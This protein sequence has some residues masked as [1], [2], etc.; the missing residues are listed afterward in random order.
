MGDKKRISATLDP[1]IVERIDAFAERESRN[2]SQALENL[3]RENLDEEGAR[4]R[5]SESSSTGAAT[6]IVGN[7]VA[8]SLLLTTVAGAVAV[9]VPGTTGAALPVAIAGAAWMGVS[10]TV[11]LTGRARRLDEY[12]EERANREQNGENTENTV[13]ADGGVEA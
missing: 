11:L 1:E 10:L 7:V 3:A 13:A 5:E 12:L 6:Q 8:L 9:A 4:R 2:R